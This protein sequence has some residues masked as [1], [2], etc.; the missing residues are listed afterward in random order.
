MTVPSGLLTACLRAGSPTSMWPSLVNATTLGNA[1]P[2]RLVP[3]ALGTMTGRPACKTL[4]A[5]FDVPKSMPIIFVIIF[6]L[7]I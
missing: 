7:R 5:E 1:L 2:Y 6:F 3:S 4:A